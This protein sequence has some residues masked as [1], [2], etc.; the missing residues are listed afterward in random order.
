MAEVSDVANRN[1]LYD[2]ETIS[3]RVLAEPLAAGSP[4]DLPN[5]L[6]KSDCQVRQATIVNISRLT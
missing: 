3:T 4:S 6:A 5:T 2:W 1:L